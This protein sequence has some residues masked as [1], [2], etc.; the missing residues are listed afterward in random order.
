MLFYLVHYLIS[1]C[2]LV[3]SSGYNYTV[4]VDGTEYTGYDLWINDEKVTSTR[5]VMGSNLI[6][7][8]RFMSRIYIRPF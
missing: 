8:L 7:T 5:N 3:H 6:F 2:C 1:I 4:Q